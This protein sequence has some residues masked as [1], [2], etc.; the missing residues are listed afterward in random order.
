MQ[1][2]IYLVED[3]SAIIDIYATVMKKAGIDVDVMSLGADVLKKLG[4]VS[5]GEEIKPSLILLDL[6][7]PDMNGLDILAEVKKNP[8]LKDILVFILSN[9]S[10]AQLPEGAAKPDKFIIKANITPTEL[11]EVVQKELQS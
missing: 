8:T 5:K 3:D 4:L 1:K 11:L 7:L 9:Q 6:I 2:R 10:D